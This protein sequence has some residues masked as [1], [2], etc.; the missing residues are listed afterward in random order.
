MSMASVQKS[1]F[2]DIERTIQ[3]LAAARL[4][5]AKIELETFGK[6]TDAGVNRLLRSLSLY[7]Y[8]QPMSRESRLAM[9]RKIKSLIIRYGIPAIWFTLNPNDITNPIKLKLVAYRTRETGDAED[10][11][12]KSGSDLQEG[13]TRHIG[14]PQ[15]G[16][17]LP[18]RD[19][20]VLPILR[21]DWEGFGVRAHQPILCGCRD[22]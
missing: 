12:E 15:F 6:T 14:P 18:S 10:F 11:P 8:S 22:E 3:G 4:D 7:G 20:H 21:E 16:A 17:L 9:R 1:D 19:V 5:K 2:A 13:S